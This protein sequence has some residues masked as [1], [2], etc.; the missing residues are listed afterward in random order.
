MAEIKKGCV[1]SN[2]RCPH[3]KVWVIYV[4][5]DDCCGIAL[6]HDDE[7]CDIGDFYSNIQLPLWK[8][9]NEFYDVPEV[10]TKMQKGEE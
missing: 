6:T 2:K 7:C 10:V 9:T 4:D 8:L 3:I 5:E 1:L